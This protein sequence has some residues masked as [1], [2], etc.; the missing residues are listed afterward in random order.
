MCNDSV[1]KEGQ[2]IGDPTEIALV[3][4]SE[5]H[6]LPVEKMR[7][8]YQRLG[9]IPFDSDRKLMSTKYR[10]HGVPTILVK[11]ALDILL[12]R[13]DRIRIGDEIRPITEQDVKEILDKNQAF[14]EQGLRVLAFA[15]KEQKP[16]S[17]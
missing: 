4:F 8:K 9:E 17:S 6:D 14:S 16:I 11:G 12:K 13:T 15:Y 7:E 3:N 10:L 5:K 1:Q 2:E